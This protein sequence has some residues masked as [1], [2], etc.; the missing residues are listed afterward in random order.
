MRFFTDEALEA[1]D[2]QW[3]ATQ[4]SYNAHIDSLRPLVPR[5]A[6][7]LASDPA[8]NL[9]DGLIRTLHIDTDN[10]NIEL[11]VVRGVTRLALSFREA[12]IQP[13]NIYQL[14]CAVGAEYRAGH[15]GRVLT[16]IREQEVD[17]S[18]DG[19]TLLRLRLDPFHT[20]AIAFGALDPIEVSAH[21]EDVTD[22]G[23]LTL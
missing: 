11:V 7:R 1:D 8:V 17:V 10:G 13:P 12:E 20:F 9:A 5:E 22:P 23:K 2:D 15:F 19:R 21:A 16:T 6:I 4:Q 14:A 3:K 18:G